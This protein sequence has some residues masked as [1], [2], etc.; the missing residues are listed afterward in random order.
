MVVTQYEYQVFSSSLQLENEMCT[1]KLVFYQSDRKRIACNLTGLTLAAFLC[2]QRL[3]A[4]M[5]A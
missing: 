2:C 3:A 5:P 4:V 1:G